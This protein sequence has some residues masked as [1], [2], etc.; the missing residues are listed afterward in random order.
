[1]TTLCT[2]S[3]PRMASKLPLYSKC[4]LGL[5]AIYNLLGT[6]CCI[7]YS[8][9]PGSGKDISRKSHVAPFVK[10]PCCAGGFLRRKIHQAPSSYSPNFLRARQPLRRCADLLIISTVMLAMINTPTS[11]TSQFKARCPNSVK[12]LLQFHKCENVPRPLSF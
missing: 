1:M 3:P 4:Q 8:G 5:F 2:S 10:P 11:S 12:T 6:L 7:V 9:A